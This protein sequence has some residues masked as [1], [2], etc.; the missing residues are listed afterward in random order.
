MPPQPLL[1]SLTAGA[2]NWLRA[3]FTNTFHGLKAKTAVNSKLKFVYCK[4]RF[5]VVLFLFHKYYAQRLQMPLCSICTFLLVS[6]CC[7]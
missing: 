6:G 5:L 3:G 2:A 1:P 4:L 7:F